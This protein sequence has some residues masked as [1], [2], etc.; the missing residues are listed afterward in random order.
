MNNLTEKWKKG[1]L[2]DGEYYCKTENGVE[3]LRTWRGLNGYLNFENMCNEVFISSMDDCEVLAEVPSYQD[4]KKLNWYAGDGVE[5]NAKLKTENKWYSEQLN[6]AVKE[7]GHLKELLEEVQ[8]KI[9]YSS[10]RGIETFAD[11][12]DTLL[13]KINQALGEE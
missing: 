2:R 10:P 12:D 5:E 9:R 1:E 3:I 8:S 7:V 13:G 6:E 11:L 4:Y